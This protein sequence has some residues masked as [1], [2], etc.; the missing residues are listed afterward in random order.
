VINSV[1]VIF[2]LTT[3]SL[4]PIFDYSKGKGEKMSLLRHIGRLANKSSFVSIIG[5]AAFVG[6]CH[7]A[8]G[9]LLSNGSF[10]AG[11]YS[12]GSDGAQDLA[13]GSTTIMGWTVITNH[14]AP[15]EA[16]NIYSIVPEDGNVSLDLQ[17]YSDGSPYGGVEQAISTVAGGAY[18]LS[19]W[20][21]VQNSV[22]SAVGPAS[23]TASA[24]SA[25]ENFTNT[26]TGSGNQWEEFSMDFTASGTS[27]NI[28][29]SGLSTTGGAYIGLD[30]ATVIAVPEPG[31]LGIVLVGSCLCLSG[32]RWSS[33]VR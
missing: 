24:G 9:N 27:T 7:L 21:G 14:V 25:S 31:A 33:Q 20:L 15:I 22:G 28:S 2:F 3:S 12:F 26:L 8:K 32:R 19:F 23:L 13:P 6:S 16:A 1:P 17:G 10:E 30:N 11:T 18:Q 5:A 29:L 4:R